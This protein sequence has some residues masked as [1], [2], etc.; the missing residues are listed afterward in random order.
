MRHD[1]QIVSGARHPRA[2]TGTLQ[3]DDRPR[4]LRTVA[5]ARGAAPRALWGAAVTEPGAGPKRDQWANPPRLG[6]FELPAPEPQTGE[7]MFRGLNVTLADFWG[8]AFS[9]LAVNTIRSTLA[10]FLVARALGDPRS[11]REEWTDFD[12]LMPDGT[13]VEVKSAGYLQRWRQWKP[14]LIR[15][16]SFSG[17]SW[18]PHTGYFAEE[19]SIRADVFVFAVQTSTNPEAYDPF[20]VGQ[21]EFYVLGAASV[22]RSGYRSASLTWVRRQAGPAVDFA[23]LAEAVASVRQP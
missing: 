17:R 21:W 20:D 15:F 23:G 5:V 8:W 11:V 16:G 1:E 6:G 22:A 3:G 2:L 14:S 13:R 9:D 19:R 12:V 10:E 18:D 4:G 7:R